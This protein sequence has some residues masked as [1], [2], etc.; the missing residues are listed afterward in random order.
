GRAVWTLTAGGSRTVSSLQ[1]RLRPA[2]ARVKPEVVAQL[3]ADLDANDFP[4]R[5]K[6]RKELQQ[7]GEESESALRQAL[8]KPSSLEVRRSLQEVLSQLEAE[9]KAPV[10][11]VLAGVRAVEVLEQIGTPEA[12]QVLEARRRGMSWSRHGTSCSHVTEEAHNALE[13]LKRTGQR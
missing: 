1:A 9:R 5:T 13:R 2:A 3:I 8:A 7:L 11:E 6:A 10:G 4:T 12:R